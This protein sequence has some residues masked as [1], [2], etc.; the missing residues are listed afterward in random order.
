MS[1][2]VRRGSGAHS[3]GLL[4]GAAITASFVGIAVIGQF[5]TPYD[6]AALSIIDQLQAPNSRHWCGTD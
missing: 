1:A 6:P 3:G 2:A 5:W 4:A